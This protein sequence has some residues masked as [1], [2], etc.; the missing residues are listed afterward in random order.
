MRLNLNKKYRNLLEKLCTLP[1]LKYR[2]VFDA[3]RLYQVVAEESRI[4]SVGECRFM[5]VLDMVFVESKP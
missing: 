2:K 4:A 1:E 3:S 5:A